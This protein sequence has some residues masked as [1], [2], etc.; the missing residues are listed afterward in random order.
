MTKKQFKEINARLKKWRK[1]RGID[2]ESQRD[3]LVLNLLEELVE[4][5]RA[6]NDLEK[7]DALCDMYIFLLNSYPLDSGIKTDRQH[8]GFN[9]MLSMIKEMNSLDIKDCRDDVIFR[10]EMMFLVYSIEFNLKELGYEPYLCMCE[11]LQEIESRSGKYDANAKK[12]IK[13]TSKEA[14]AKW[15][16]ADYSKCRL[17]SKKA[18]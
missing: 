16:K 5:G 1:M 3:G 4:F 18:V 10:N 11:T 17:D 6:K 8:F 13:D 7:V 15:Y 12:W 2:I 9:F 14:K